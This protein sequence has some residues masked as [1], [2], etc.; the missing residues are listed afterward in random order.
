[1]FLVFRKTFDAVSAV[2]KWVYEN[3]L[4]HRIRERIG[5]HALLKVR[6]PHIT[7][8]YC[9]FGEFSYNEIYV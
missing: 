6:F 2:K 8:L 7:P 4:P 1:M 5:E 9:Y 3:N